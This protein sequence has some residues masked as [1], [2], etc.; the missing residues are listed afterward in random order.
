ML[1]IPGANKVLIYT[2][3]NIN[4]DHGRIVN[5]E[6][7]SLYCDLG[8]CTSIFCCFLSV[9]HLLLNSKMLYLII[10]FEYCGNITLKIHST[11]IMLAYMWYFTSFN[12]DCD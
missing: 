11:A 6:D 10:I 4:C 2:S 1:H 9:S 12:I 3:S 8:R 7:S 5:G